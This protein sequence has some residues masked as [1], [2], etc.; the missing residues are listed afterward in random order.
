MARE[1][2]PEMLVIAREARG[3]TQSEL[4][5]R[6]KI[7]PETISRIESGFRQPT[8]E[9]IAGFSECLEFT[10]DFFFLD[11]RVRGFGSGCIYHRKRKKASQPILKRL[12]ALV[13]V[14][15][16]QLKKILQS[17]ELNTANEFVR[18]DIDEFGGPEECARAIRA[19]WKLPPGPVHN[20]TRSIEDAGGVVIR[21]DFGTQ[22]VDAVSQWMAD[23]PPLFLVNS[24]IPTD[25]CRWTLAH[26]LGHIVM[27]QIP[28]TNMEQEADK[29]AAEFLTPQA[30]IKP[31]LHY[32]RL[33]E[34]ANLKIHWKVS[35]SSLIM[36]A[37][38][39]KTISPRTK[40]YLFTQM[41]QRGWNL[42]EPVELPKETPA[43]FG[44]LVGVYSSE[45]D[46][47]VSDLSRLLFEPEERVRHLLPPK[48][49]P[50]VVA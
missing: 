50:Q 38:E 10:E 5:A 40:T 48:P 30:E 16:I 49:G 22:Y 47:S 21:C 42:N 2:N 23:A 37:G 43:L 45:L 26:E 41:S 18:L 9:H 46:Y 19:I 24:R 20:L 35:I 25:R 32:V 6:L 11:E 15:R 3:L 1:F 27:H 8:A 44:E 28:T 36:R 33:P 12:L 7:A 31:Y 17:A 14:R 34:L 13:N 39:L 29:F 4:G